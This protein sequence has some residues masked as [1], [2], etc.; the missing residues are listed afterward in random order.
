MTTDAITTGPGEAGV[1]RQSATTT[2]PSSTLLNI[3]GCHTY[4]APE[5]D[6]G[7]VPSDAPESPDANGADSINDDG[8]RSENEGSNSGAEDNEEIEEDLDEMVD[9]LDL[10]DV[11]GKE[12]GKKKLIYQAILLMTSSI[13]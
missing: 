6:N 10:L 11:E 13:C 7:M 9:V 5:S 3:E 2:L 4:V 8:S 12:T 1:D